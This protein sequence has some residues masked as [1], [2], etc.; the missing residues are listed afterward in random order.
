MGEL[1]ANLSKG[2][3]AIV[4]SAAA[5]SGYALESPEWNNGV[6][7]YCILNGIKNK[8]AD[9]NKDGSITVSELRDYV[10]QEVQSITKGAQK[11][12]SRRDN[13][14]FDFNVW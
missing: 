8:T 3:G 14:S 2:S 11:P 12:T 4:I 13:V 9:L 7:T 10:S 1:F 6:F 5:G